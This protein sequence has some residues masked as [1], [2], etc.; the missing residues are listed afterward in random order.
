MLQLLDGPC[1]GTYLVLRAPAYLR[2]VL[3]DKGKKDVLDLV[4]DT[5][6]ESEKVHVYKREGGSA[7]AHLNFGGGRGGWYA[8][9]VY[10]YMPSVDGEKLRDNAK[11]QAWALAEAK[12]A[13]AE[14]GS[15]HNFDSLYM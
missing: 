12:A 5:P 4:E 7:T 9:A 8:M 6:G 2:A 15:I 3:D 10:H 14:A 13:E 1:Q 11:W